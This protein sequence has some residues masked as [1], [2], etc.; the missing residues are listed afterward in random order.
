LEPWDP[1][2]IRYSSRHGVEFHIIDRITIPLVAA[3]PMTAT[4]REQTVVLVEV[5]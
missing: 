2:R 1:I 5:T 3:A 4:T